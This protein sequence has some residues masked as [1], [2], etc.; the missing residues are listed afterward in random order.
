[1][2]APYREIEAAKTPER[3]S[4]ELVYRPQE[5]LD[6][7]AGGHAGF[8]MYAIPA[9]LGAIVGKLWAIEAGVVVFVALAAAAYGW[10]RKRPKDVVVLRVEGG[11]LSV[12]PFGSKET[13]FR[14]K[15]DELE[16]V[17][18][19]TKSVER[20]MDVGANAVNIGMGPLAP[21]IGPPSETKRITL[22]SAKRG[23]HTLTQEFFGHAETIEWFA[24]IRSFL[25]SCGWTP[26]SEREEE[27]EDDDAQ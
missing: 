24:K 23:T 7:M 4:G 13:T 10:S 6:R 11:E 20:V 12:L 3:K 18:L 2:K 16:D 5:R 15:L 14:V 26:L 1:V 21:N 25:R 27:E 9:L 22:E 19:E 8:R 17:V